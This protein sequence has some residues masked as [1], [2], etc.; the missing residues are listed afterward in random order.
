MGRLI[1]VGRIKVRVW[2]LLTSTQWTQPHP[3]VQNWSVASPIITTASPLE[4]LTLWINSQWLRP[5]FLTMGKQGWWSRENG[6]RSLSSLCQ[7][8][9]TQRLWP[10]HRGLVSPSPS[11]HKTFISLEHKLNNSI[12]HQVAKKITPKRKVC[13]GIKFNFCINICFFIVMWKKREWA[14]PNFLRWNLVFVSLLDFG[15]IWFTRSVYTT[16][17]SSRDC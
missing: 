16:P 2:E 7:L 14:K 4:A 12:F 11:N 6:D 5:D 8:S 10:L 15:L 9:M 13:R 1:F 17:S 3:L